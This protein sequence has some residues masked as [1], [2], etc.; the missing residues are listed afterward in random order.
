MKQVI[1]Q[2][3][4][5]EAFQ[6]TSRENTPQKSSSA[7]AERKR[8]ALIDKEPNVKKVHLP[9]IEDKPKLKVVQTMSEKQAGETDENDEDEEI[10]KE[11]VTKDVAGQGT[12]PCNA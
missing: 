7:K 12:I 11:E 10:D 1:K 4:Q 6:L 5:N 8:Q 2:Q 9:F 3:F